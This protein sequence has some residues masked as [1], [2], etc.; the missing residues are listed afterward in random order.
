MQRH[1]AASQSVGSD[2]EMVIVY[3]GD[4]LSLWKRQDGTYLQIA[5]EIPTNDLRYT[6]LKQIAHIHVDISS[7]VEACIKNE[8]PYHVGMR[9]LQMDLLPDIDALLQP[10]SLSA[11][12]PDDIKWQREILSE[13]KAFI[14]QLCESSEKLL[15]DELSRRHDHFVDLL[16]EAILYNNATATAVQLR[17]LHALT[18]EWQQTHHLQAEKSRVIMVSPYGP[19]LGRIETQYF[20]RWYEKA[21]RITNIEDNML[22]SKEELPS[23]FNSLD[24]L[25]DLIGEFLMGSELN[26]RIGKK[27]LGDMK[28]MFRD[29]LEP[30]AEAILRELFSDMEAPRNV[31]V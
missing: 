9:E 29:I 18:M 8:T 6:R 1:R 19:R 26:K 12:H 22:Y 17:R 28:K 2:I 30:H 13:S 11:L 15:A 20:M 7:I 25:K 10:D 21:L 27:I 23:K 5:K 4:E 16:K 3:K 24:I 14:T 31:V